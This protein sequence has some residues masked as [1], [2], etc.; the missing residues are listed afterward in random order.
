M[1]KLSCKYGQFIMRGRMDG[2]MAED[3]ARSRVCVKA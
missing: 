1:L 3:E 2:W